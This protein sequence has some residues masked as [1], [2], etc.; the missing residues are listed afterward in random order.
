[1][2]ILPVRTIGVMGDGRTYDFA[3]ALRAVTSVDGTWKLNQNKPDD[4]RLRAADAM[5]QSLIGQETQT[6]ADLM[7]KPPAN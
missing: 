1:M 6:L 3:C 7:R 4:V 2:A 5:A